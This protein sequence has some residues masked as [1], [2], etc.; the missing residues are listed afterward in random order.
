[1]TNDQ[2]T[3]L[4]RYMNEKFDAIDRRFELT[5][6]Q[7]SVDAI[8]NALDGMNGR[9]STI[10]QED[11]MRDAQFGRMVKWGKKVGAKTGVPLE[12]L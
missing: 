6:T 11:V 1:M 9:V 3:K 8:L 10:E 5:A 7:A 12:D 2:F 4:F